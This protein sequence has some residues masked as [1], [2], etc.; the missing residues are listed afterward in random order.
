MKSL[1]LEFVFGSGVY[2]LPL[3]STFFHNIKKIVFLGQKFQKMNNRSLQLMS[4]IK[5]GCYS[6][7]KKNILF[8][9]MVKNFSFWEKK[10]QLLPVFSPKQ[11]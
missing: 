9:L 4:I 6:I 3:A 7:I 5:S 1:D 8:Y 2:P 10:S 11:Y